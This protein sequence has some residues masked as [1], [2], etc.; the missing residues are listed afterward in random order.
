MNIKYVHHALIQ[1]PNTL[2]DRD[3]TGKAT[4]S[5]RKPQ[6]VEEARYNQ[7]QLRLE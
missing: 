7:S 6:A 1:W 2:R 3:Q 5:A 4:T